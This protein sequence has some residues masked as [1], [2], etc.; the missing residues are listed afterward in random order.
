MIR[1]R[2]PLVLGLL[3]LATTVV[4]VWQVGVGASSISRRTAGHD[5]PPIALSDLGSPASLATLDEGT[6]TAIKTGT[7]TWSDLRLRYQPAKGSPVYT[8][9]NAQGQ[10][11]LARDGATDCP[12]M[13]GQTLLSNGPVYQAGVGRVT[14]GNHGTITYTETAFYGLARDGITQIVL[15]GT[16]GQ[17]YNTPV[18]SGL[19]DLEGISLKPK[20]VEAL[21]NSGHVVWSFDESQG[22]S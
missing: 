11:C 18:V 1:N 6:Q 10:L 3:G 13:P 16:E 8:F 14:I 9:R 17:R 7:G 21:D 22:S 15:T 20:L 2:K 19:F 12:G 5:A 4:L